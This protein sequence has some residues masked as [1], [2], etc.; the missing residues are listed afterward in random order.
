MNILIVS[1]TPFEIAPF[2]QFIQQEFE[3][4][5]QEVFAYNDLNIHFL[6]TGVG[7]PLTAYHLGRALLRTP[8][9]LV[10]NAGIAGAFHKELK[11]GDVVQ[12]INDRF[13]DLGVQEQDGRFVDVHELDLIG[14]DA[15]PFESGQLLNKDA[16][17][18]SFLPQV[19]AIS[20]N[21]VHGEASAITAIRQKY[22]A[23]IETM[24]GAAVA[25]VCLSENI[26]FLQIRSISNYVEPR[27]KD[28]WDIPLAI[29]QLN[30]TLVQIVE[31][32]KPE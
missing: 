16:A 21:K 8:F 32:L 20:V 9:N 3:D 28:N 18:F 23:A 22:Q 31:S 7:L 11:I 2:R 1:A 13:G 14:T 17:S 27:N 25:Y 19:S 24:E 15:F 30:D 4:H 6:V 12:V 5:G 10:I 29:K 26:P